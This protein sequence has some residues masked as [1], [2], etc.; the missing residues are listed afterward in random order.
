MGEGCITMY[1]GMHD[2]CSI[3]PHWSCIVVDQPRANRHST[4]PTTTQAIVATTIPWKT[5][6]VLNAEFNTIT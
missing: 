3:F 1:S 2:Q 6:Q 4:I 5:I